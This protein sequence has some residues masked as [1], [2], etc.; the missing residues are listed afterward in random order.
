MHNPNL[1]RGQ[2]SNRDRGSFQVKRG[3]RERWGLWP[4]GGRTPLERPDHA[5]GADRRPV[6]CGF[7]FV[8]LLIFGEKATK[9]KYVFSLSSDA[10]GQGHL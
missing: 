9:P 6:E 4:T 2:A 3:S 7:V 8:S 1:Y 5:V 10:V